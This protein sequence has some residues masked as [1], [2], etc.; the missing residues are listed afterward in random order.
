[1]QKGLL[2][3]WWRIC[4]GFIGTFSIFFTTNNANAIPAATCSDT[5][6]KLS[7]CNF[8]H[9]DNANADC[10]ITVSSYTSIPIFTTNN[11]EFRTSGDG[12]YATGPFYENGDWY[13]NPNNFTSTRLAG[14][15]DNVPWFCGTTWFENNRSSITQ[16]VFGAPPADTCDSTVYTQNGVK[17]QKCETDKQWCVE[18]ALACEGCQG[19]QEL[20][21]SLYGYTYTNAFRIIGCAQSGYQLKGA[22]V[23]NDYT[24][25]SG[26]SCIACPPHDGDD[27]RSGFLTYSSGFDM[28]YFHLSEADSDSES[29]YD[30]T[31]RFIY[32]TSASTGSGGTGICFEDGSMSFVS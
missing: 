3:I 15:S 26:I 29:L 12:F 13:M 27:N 24:S 31:G 25:L 20:V 22:T 2:N 10:R 16:S 1:M 28:C 7:G 14:P 9:G 6:T 11:C 5:T 18:P 30:S 17:Y 23:G 19:T 21:A 8:G 32:D 4:G